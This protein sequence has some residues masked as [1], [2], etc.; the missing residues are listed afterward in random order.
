[1]LKPEARSFEPPRCPV[2]RHIPYQAYTR[3]RQTRAEWASV[4]AAFAPGTL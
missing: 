3:M 4:R 2:T 1:M